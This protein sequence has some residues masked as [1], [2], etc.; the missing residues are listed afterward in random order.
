PARASASRSWR[1]APRR[2][3][4]ALLLAGPKSVF[5]GWPGSV[6]AR[7]RSTCARQVLALRDR[8]RSQVPLLR[9]ACARPPWLR[10]AP[11]RP[12]QAQAAQAASRRCRRVWLSRRFDSVLLCCSCPCEGRE[13]SRHMGQR[14]SVVLSC[15]FHV[16]ASVSV[17]VAAPCCR[18]ACRLGS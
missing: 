9:G 1:R 2:R 14:G 6:L 16:V 10:Q 18:G 15:C 7:S 4:A 5:L 17:G 11:H 12:Q 3:D 8:G 13:N